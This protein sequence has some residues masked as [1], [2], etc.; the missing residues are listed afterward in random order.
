[1]SLTLETDRGQVMAASTMIAVP[2]DVLL[3][4]APCTTTSGLVADAAKR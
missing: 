3:L 2:V 4:S 1:M